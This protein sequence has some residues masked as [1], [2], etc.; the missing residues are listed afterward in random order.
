MIQYASI[1]VGIAS[2][3]IPMTVLLT[4]YIQTVS[5]LKKERREISFQISIGRKDDVLRLKQRLDNTDGGIDGDTVAG[6]NENEMEL[7][8]TQGEENEEE[9]LKMELI[10][11]GMNPQKITMMQMQGMS[12]QQIAEMTGKNKNDE[13]DDEKEET[14]S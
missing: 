1:I 3:I 14:K 11:Q 7:G 9:K 2:I 5:S 12:L 8:S 6:F 10:S 4:Q 13:D